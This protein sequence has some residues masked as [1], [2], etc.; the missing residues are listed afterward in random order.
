MRVRNERERESGRM[1]EEKSRNLV[2]YEGEEG[3]MIKVQ[4]REKADIL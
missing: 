4:S 1:E 3:T 2:G